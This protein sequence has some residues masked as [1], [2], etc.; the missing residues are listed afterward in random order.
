MAFGDRIS[1]RSPLINGSSMAG[2]R[3]S[4]ERSITCCGWH[5][6]FAELKARAGPHALQA[7]EQE[8]IGRAGG[9]SQAA[10]IAE[11][12]HVLPDFIGNRSPLADAGARGGLMGMDLREEAASLQEFY[13]AGLCGLAYGLADIV[14]QARSLR[15]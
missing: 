6:A 14:A 11:G 1:A 12:L 13:M 15:L 8:I 2:S 9:L 4:A 10:L 5:P 3:R 7:L